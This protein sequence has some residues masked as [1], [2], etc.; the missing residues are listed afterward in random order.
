MPVHGEHRHMIAV[1]R[2]VKSELPNA[3]VIVVEDGS[4]VELAGGR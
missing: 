2:L 1:E 3:S 4:E